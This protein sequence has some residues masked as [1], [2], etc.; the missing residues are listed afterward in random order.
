MKKNDMS[1][2]KVLLDDLEEWMTA[3]IK[4]VY[5]ENPRS[6]EVI[7]ERLINHICQNWGG[8]QVYIHK[9]QS[10]QVAKRNAA[11]VAEFTGNNHR[12]LAKKFGVSTQWVYTIL[13]DAANRLPRED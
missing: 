13:R 1:V 4:L 5:P 11:I 3:E 12:H 8:Q 2:A 6:A 9:R 7:A 10:E